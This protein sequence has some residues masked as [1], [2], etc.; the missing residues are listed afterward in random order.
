MGKAV[1]VGPRQWSMQVPG[2]V[3]GNG[4]ATAPW[5]VCPVDAATG[6]GYYIQQKLDLRALT[7]A[8]DAGRGV[9]LG[10]VTLQEAGPWDITG[11]ETERAIV[12]YDFLTTVRPTEEGVLEAIWAGLSLAGGT[13]GFL[14]PT[15]VTDSDHTPLNPSQVVWGYWRQM[16]VDRNIVGGTDMFVVTVSSSYFGEGE[17]LVGPEV[18]YTR[19]VGTVADATQVMVPSANLACYA[20]AVALTEPQE[21]TQMMRSVAR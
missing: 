13:P 15:G 5:E 1:T 18:W 17:I 14:H 11:G 21:M 2:S 6:H 9:Q 4:A 10:N 19:F 16:G 7:V 20:Q 8:P 12:V 3:F